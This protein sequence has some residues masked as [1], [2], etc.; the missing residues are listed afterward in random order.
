MINYDNVLST[1][2]AG[3][4][5]SGIR[6][7]FDLLD[8][9]DDVISLT[10]GQPDFVTPW[11]IREKAIRSIEDGK[12]YYT[13]NS[14]LPEL[15]RAIADY[16][17]RRFSLVY[18][19]K[20]EIIVTVGGS[21]AIDMAMRAIIDPG[22]EVI[23]PMPSYVCYEPMT[24]LLGAVPVTINT[25]SENAFKLTAQELKKAITP[26][27]KALILPF[28]N[29][30]TG[31]VLDAEDVKE[32]AEVLK[33]TDIA[34]ISD[35]IYAELTYGRRHVSIASVPGMRER[36]VLVSGVSKA[37]AMT[38]W[39]LGYIAAPKEITRQILKIHQYAIMCAPTASQFA[40]VE[41]FDNSDEDIEYMRAQYNRRRTMLLEGLETIGLPCFEPRGA[42]YVFPQ[43][44]QGCKMTSEEF[45]S[46]L[47]N[48]NLLAIVPGT[49]FGDCGE[50]FAR[51]SYAYSV[52]HI[53]GALERLEDFV[54]KIRS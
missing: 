13:A 1:R 20:N 10:V 32:I 43:V 54:K 47:L 9:R 16:L 14:G 12:T 46:R 31:A 35:E 41:A 7:F 22:D 44:T 38:G 53:A 37:Y 29:N 33:D 39:R 8:G 30:P 6:K 48:E 25:K 4:K 52:R 23:I 42:F 27:T 21:E 2:A 11:H 17:N 26:R 3:I 45:C 5:P 24:Q 50:G 34:V 49:A 51:L 19:S 40:A 18:D 15:R 28:P 36:T